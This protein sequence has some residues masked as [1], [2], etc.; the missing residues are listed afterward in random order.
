MRAERSSTIGTERLTNY[1]LQI[2]SRE[3]FVAQLTSN[4]PARPEYFLKDAEINRTGA[5]ALSDLPPLRAIAPAELK[6]HAGRG[7]DR[8]RCASGRRV[9]RRRMCRAR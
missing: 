6:T 1:A 4:L 9:C 5:A 8:A 2:K 7:R 3:E